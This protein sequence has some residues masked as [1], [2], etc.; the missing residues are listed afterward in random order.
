[1]RVR[2]RAN[3]GGDGVAMLAFGFDGGVTHTHLIH[4][5]SHGGGV[6][7]RV[8]PLV[9]AHVRPEPTTHVEHGAAPQVHGA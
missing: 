2:V 9:A 5:E 1:M 8:F 7:R 6:V 3:R 4:G